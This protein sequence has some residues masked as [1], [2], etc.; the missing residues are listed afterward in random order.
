MTLDHIDRMVRQANPVPDLRLLESAGSSVPDQRGR[1]DMQTDDRIV[2]ETREQTRPRRGRLAWAAA[3]AAVIFGVLVLFRP[4]NEIPV[5]DQVVGEPTDASPSPSPPEPGARVEGIGAAFVEAYVTFDTDT[6]ASF[7]AATADLSG[8][9]GGEEWRLGNRWFEATGFEATLDDCHLFNAERPA[10]SVRCY[11]WFHG[12]RSDDLGMDPFWPGWFDV[13]VRN[14]QVVSAAMHLEVTSN[15][16]SAQVWE[17]FAEW[18]S[19]TYPADAA[20]MYTD[21]SYSQQRITEQSIGLWRQHTDEYVQTKAVDVTTAFVEA[22]G[23][24]D[25]T[26]AASYLAP[27]ADVSRLEGGE[28]WL[29]G[30]RWLEETGFELIPEACRAVSSGRVRCGFSFS[31]LRSREL[32]LGPYPGSHF[33]FEVGN[34]GI[35]SASMTLEVDASGF[36]A[37]VWEPF[38]EWVSTTYPEDA[39]VMYSDSSHSVERLTGESI[40]LWGQHTAEFVALNGQG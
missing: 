22:Y 29:S 30:N 7:L 39:A 28:E 15:G 19:T 1:T 31:G 9:E 16:F 27:D 4:A 3:V 37:Q 8:L 34:G 10:D 35:V 38:A 14:D 11:F 13:V 32:G 33:D 20:V 5:T 26:R 25:R 2:T 17:P 6:A 23:G 12:L 21:S 24:F 36:S 40:A 18:V